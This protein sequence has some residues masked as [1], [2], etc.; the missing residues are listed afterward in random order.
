VLTS[1]SVG[2]LHDFDAG[3]FHPVLCDNLCHVEQHNAAVPDYI[4]IAVLKALKLSA[5]LLFLLTLATNLQ[6]YYG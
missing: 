6:C 4:C 5:L 1:E 3:L 2:F